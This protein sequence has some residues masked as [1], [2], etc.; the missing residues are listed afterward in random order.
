MYKK[1]YI[2]TGLLLFSILLSACG[3]AVAAQ[4]DDP[5]RQTL[6]V[7]GIGKS[8]LTPD[9]VHIM[10]GVHTEGPDVA[11]AVASN[12][13][14]TQQVKDILMDYDIKPEDIQTNYFSIWP[15]QQ[16]DSDGQ[17]QGILYMVDNT[18][19]VTLPN[20]S[21]IGEVLDTVIDAGANRIEGIQFD[22]EDRSAALTEARQAAVADAESQAQELADAAG[23]TLGAIQNISSSGSGIPSPMYDGIG[24]GGGAAESSVPVSPGQLVVTVEVHAVY[25]MNP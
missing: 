21:Q 24:G 7:N 17:M 19:R 3:T 6:S 11:E 22:V 4:S 25:E 14:K 12:N 23:L 8:Y 20:A 2:F 9:I 10:I 16:Y 18:L 1:T 13:Q 5:V 15:N